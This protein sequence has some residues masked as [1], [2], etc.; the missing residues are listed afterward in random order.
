VQPA[1]ATLRFDANP[2]AL[3]CYEE[4]IRRLHWIS[5]LLQKNTLCHVRIFWNGKKTHPNCANPQCAS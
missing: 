3:T 1:L 2:Q 5:T 4:F